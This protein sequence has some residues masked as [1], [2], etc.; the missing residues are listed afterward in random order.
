MD[1]G[2]GASKPRPGLLVTLDALG[3]IYK[4]KEPIATQYIKV[5]RDCGIQAPIT[6]KD[7]MSAFKKAFREISSEYPNYG[8]GQLDSPRMWWKSLV[9][10][11]FRRVVPEDEIPG[12]L[13]HELYTRFSSGAAYELYPDVLPFF[14]SMQQLKQQYS[15]PQD[16]AI[17][18]GVISNGDPRVKSILQSL[19]LRVGVES[20]PKVEAY[21]DR[22]SRVLGD[23]G[24]HTKLQ[25]LK[26]AA[27]SPW[28]NVYNPL[29]H[30]DLVV[31]SY[32]VGAE[33]PDPLPFLQAEVLANMNF[34]SKMEQLRKDWSPSID[35]MKHRLEVNRQAA[36]FEFAKCIH[37]GD[38]YD[39]DYQ[40][41]IGAG[42]EALHLSREGEQEPGPEGT[43]VVTSLDEA[44][45]AIR[46]MAVDNLGSSNQDTSS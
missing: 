21:K 30:V 33:K 3:T 28:Y 35:V 1:M 6:E 27:K 39:K 46:I 29:N 37:I 20:M 24:P 23:V 38:D 9:N 15:H 12:H 26:D 32:E 34:V 18:V 17:F 42:Y 44:A 5:A 2:V 13:A 16:P 36:K 19:D 31:T 14:W 25:D 10:D 11:T 7:L 8:K 22:A 40:G 4:F 43:N 45:M 41:A